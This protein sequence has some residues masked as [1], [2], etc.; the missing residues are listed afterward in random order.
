V[1]SVPC[2]IAIVARAAASSFA[3]FAS[4]ASSFGG[5]APPGSHPPVI[6]TG[7]EGRQSLPALGEGICGGQKSS[8]SR[9]EISDEEERRGSAGLF[10]R[11]PLYVQGNGYCFPCCTCTVH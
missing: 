1:P 2:V 11:S 8:A 5:C 4:H 3:A 7:A 10:P 6:W 9:G